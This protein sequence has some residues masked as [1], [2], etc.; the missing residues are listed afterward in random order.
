MPV[1]QIIILLATVYNRAV[2]TDVDVSHPGYMKN[3]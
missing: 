1:L 2:V 3:R